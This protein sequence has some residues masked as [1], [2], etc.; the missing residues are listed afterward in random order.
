[1]TNTSRVV[2][3]IVCF[4]FFTILQEE[5]ISRVYVKELIG[6]LWSA[7]VCRDTLLLLATN[8]HAQNYKGVINFLFTASRLNGDADTVQLCK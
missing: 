3:L 6:S 4:S 1:M 5:D 8:Y 7:E 2:Q